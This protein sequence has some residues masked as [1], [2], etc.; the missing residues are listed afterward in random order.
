VQLGFRF[1]KAAF[2]LPVAARRRLRRVLTL[3]E[4]ARCCAHASVGERD[5]ELRDRI[6]GETLVRVG[7]DE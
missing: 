5:G 4:R 3:M 2:Q 1:A 6:R 7:E